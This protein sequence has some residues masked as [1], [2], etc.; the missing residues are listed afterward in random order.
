M[1]S[2]FSVPYL[3]TCYIE[4]LSVPYVALRDVCIN[5]GRLYIMLRLQYFNWASVEQPFNTFLGEKYVV[6][7][8][9]RGVG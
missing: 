3:A 5:S 6:K 7:I 1:C 9:E 4:Y 8:Y 2:S